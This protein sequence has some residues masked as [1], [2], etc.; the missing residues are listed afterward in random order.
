MRA[1]LWPWIVLLAGCGAAPPPASRA[2]T[3]DTHRAHEDPPA[4]PSA[5][6]LAADATFADLVAAAVHEDTMRAS[7][8]SAGCLLRESADGYRLEADLSVAVRG[9]AEAPSGL[10]ARAEASGGRARVLTRLGSY[11]GP[12]PLVAVALTTIAGA[13]PRAGVLVILTASGAYVL[14]AGQGGGGSP[15]RI[16]SARVVESVSALADDEAV[17]LTAEPSLPL[18]ELA[19]LLRALP[20][21][22]AGRVALAAVLP[23]D[24]RAP[25][26][27][28]APDGAPVCDALPE[29]AEDASVG[30]LDAAAVR[31]SLSQLVPAA[32]A[33]VATSASGLGG[34]V[35]VAFR[36]DPDG[37]VRTACV[38]EDATGDATLRTCLVGA[39]ESL[40]FPAPS[41]GAVD[42]E[43]PLRLEVERDPAH[44]QRPLCE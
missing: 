14:R 6:A 33:C 28:S 22:L 23:E 11:G 8:A 15:D 18:R 5:R 21:T 38:T 40:V 2:T 41:G 43:L 24:A 25:E 37:H 7:D 1:R 30:D 17:F 13:T 29:L 42:V 34:L 19:A 9:L 20:A 4:L 32:Q 35:R 39:L 27:A 3:T 10:G 31:S 44:T 36:I 26:E 12:S 16:V